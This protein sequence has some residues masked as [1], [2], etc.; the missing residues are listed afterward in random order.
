MRQ[1]ICDIR[2]SDRVQGVDDRQAA[3]ASVGCAQ[4]RDCR[5][6]CGAGASPFCASGLSSLSSTAQ[7]KTV[8][9]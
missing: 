3:Q 1:R 6:A 5:V 7:F 4:G 2:R 9:K 8:P